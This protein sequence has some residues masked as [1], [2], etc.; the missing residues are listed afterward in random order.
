MAQAS[1]AVLPQDDG[2][3]FGQRIGTAVKGGKAWGL[4]VSAFVTRR[5]SQTEWARFSLVVLNCARRKLFV[6]SRAAW[7]IRVYS[8]FICVS[9]GMMA[10]LMDGI[11]C[12]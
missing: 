1:K 6:T 5:S 3:P 8:D 7:T 4:R 9:Q 11:P 12:H 2:N 10:A